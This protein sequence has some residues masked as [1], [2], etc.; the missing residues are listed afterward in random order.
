M[1]LARIDSPTTGL[2]RAEGEQV[3]T[4]PQ[5]RGTSVHDGVISYQGSRSTQALCHVHHLR[6]LTFL[7]EVLGQTWAKD[8]KE[9]LLDRKDE[10]QP[11]ANT[12]S[13][14]PASPVYGLA[15]TKSWPKVTKPIPLP[16]LPRSQITSESQANPNRVRLATCSIVSL[17]KSRQCYASWTIL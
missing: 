12:N 11:Q 10:V 8:M 6:E 4:P 14:C 16:H 9:L 1:S 13:M 3:W 5:F 2:M 7:E 15:T 17:R